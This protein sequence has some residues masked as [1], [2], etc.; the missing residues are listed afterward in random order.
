MKRL[1]IYLFIIVLLFTTITMGCNRKEEEKKAEN[2]KP[3]S[4]MKEFQKLTDQVVESTMEKK[5][6]DS[7][8]KTKE[9]QSKWNELYPDLQKKGISKDNVD[10]FVKDLNVLSDALIAKTLELPAVEIQEESKPPVD[11]QQ[12]GEEESQQTSAQQSSDENEKKEQDPE[13]ALLEVDPMLGITQ[14]ELVVV[15]ASVELLKHIPNFILLFD[16]PVPAPVYQLKYLVYNTN[17]TSKK[18]NW[19]ETDKTMKEINET[20]STVETKALEANEDAKTQIDQSIKELEI[21]IKQ[22][23]ERLVGLKSNVTI[24][25][26]EKLIEA[27]E[28][29]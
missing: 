12:S 22:R 4:T 19:N 8:T 15:D 2:E 14:Q 18:G 26:I 23:N 17:L 10:S 28:K 29:E 9:I 1:Y 20:W 27:F 21:V 13:K 7:L 25:V 6:A 11:E 3:P 24:E 5:W 16:A